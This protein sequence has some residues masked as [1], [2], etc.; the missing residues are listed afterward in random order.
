LSSRHRQGYGKLW[1]AKNREHARA[2]EN[3]RRNR[4]A[5]EHSARVQE[6][7]YKIMQKRADITISDLVAALNATRI[8]TYSGRN[9]TWGSTWYVAK[10]YGVVI[11]PADYAKSAAAYREHFTHHRQVTSDFIVLVRHDGAATATDIAAALND[12]GHQTVSGRPWSPHAVECF[13]SRYEVPDKYCVVCKK[14]IALE[15]RRKNSHRNTCS[16]ACAKTR[17]R[18]RQ[19]Q[20]NLMHPGQRKKLSRQRRIRLIAAYRF[21]RELMPDVEF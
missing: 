10:K 9:W 21:V 16:T 11:K 5:I 3:K 8:P 20:W 1:Y 17:L 7:I 2:C 19:Q 14:P 13:L 12:R 15:P 18:D 4:R 6:A